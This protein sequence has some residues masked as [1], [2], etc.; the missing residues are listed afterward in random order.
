MAQQPYYPNKKWRP[1][2]QYNYSSQQ[3]NY[4][5]DFTSVSGGHRQSRQ[6][7]ADV[8]QRDIDQGQAETDPW[9]QQRGVAPASNAAHYGYDERGPQQG[10]RQHGGHHAMRGNDQGYTRDFSRRFH[11]HN[12]SHNTNTAP[13]QQWRDPHVETTSHWREREREVISDYDHSR[14]ARSMDWEAGPNH[15][16]WEDHPPTAPTAHFQQQIHSHQDMWSQNSTADWQ[17]QNQWPRHQGRQYDNRQGFQQ[18]P[19]RYPNQYN[20]YDN[21]KYARPKQWNK[22]KQQ[23]SEQYHSND[24]NDARSQDFPMKQRN[25]VTPDRPLPTQ[26]TNTSQKVSTLDDLDRASQR[27]ATIVNTEI[28]NRNASIMIAMNTVGPQPS[29]MNVVS[30]T[31]NE[32][33]EVEVTETRRNM[34]ELAARVRAAEAGAVVRVGVVEAH[35]FEHV[36]GREVKARAGVEAGVEV[37]AALVAAASLHGVVRGA[38]LVEGANLVINVPER[39][40]TSASVLHPRHNAVSKHRLPTKTA[41]KMPLLKDVPLAASRAVIPTPPTAPRA[42]SQARSDTLSAPDTQP[43]TEQKSALSQFFPDAAPRAPKGHPSSNPYGTHTPPGEPDDPHSTPLPVPLNAGEMETSSVA[44]AESVITQ[45]T[46]SNPPGRENAMGPPPTRTGAKEA[47]S[48]VLDTTSK[49]PSEQGPPTSPLKT[50]QATPLASETPVQPKQRKTEDLYKIVSQVGEGTFGKVYKA[51]NQLSGVHVALK[52]IRM[53]G[54]KDGFPVTAMREIKLLQ[55]LKHDNVVK[56]HEMMVSK[57]LVYMV[58]EYAHHDL[59]GVLQQTQFILEPSHLK[60][61]S[62]Q[63]LSGLSYL[64]LKGIIHRD[65]K[66]SNILINS[67]GQLK[68]A[69]FGLARFY[70]KRRRADYTNR[71]ITLWYR[72]PELLLGATVYGPEVD[73]WSAGCIFLELFV[74]KPTFQGN[75]EIHQLDVIYQVMGTP[76]VASWPSL[77]SLPWYELVKPTIVMTNVFQKTFSRWLP[78]GALDIAEQMLTF[79]PD[80]RITAAD[81]VN[82]PYF[83]SEEPLPQPPNLSHLEGEWHELE[84]KKY[85]RKRRAEAEAEAPE[86]AIPNEISDQQ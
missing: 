35:Q 15:A 77:P 21:H 14:P 5:G 56:L 63:M 69:D 54:E 10:W 1:N 62:M 85:K 40:D 11:A 4:S 32:T 37:R 72:P 31:R 58:L 82:H 29:T 20:H 39:A 41:P 48:L 79:D 24:Y 17:E 86:S 9:H 78:P 59:V 19:K 43:Q 67:E 16:G 57:G 55:S 38:D 49:A 75:D 27:T 8:Y 18:H 83:A 33:T 13:S 12:E 71:V 45:P 26:S 60:A 34:V 3:D 6:D 51:R 2:R 73:I 74:K 23:N 84:A 42:K 61:L 47:P 76:S 53:E 25:G 30:R 46:R 22:Y 68:L 70:H 80:K 66:A 50:T 64:H 7:Q 36:L 65:L 28:Q 81:A 52:R 44:V